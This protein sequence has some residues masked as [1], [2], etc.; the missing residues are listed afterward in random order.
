MDKLVNL[1]ALKWTVIRLYP[2]L[3]EKKMWAGWQS[4]DLYL[5]F[6]QSL[7]TVCT[8]FAFCQKS[9]CQ[10]QP[11]RIVPPHLPCRSCL[12]NSVLTARDS[13]IDPT[14][15]A[16]RSLLVLQHSC[17]SGWLQLYAH[18]HD[19]VPLSNSVLMYTSCILLYTAAHYLLVIAA[20]PYK[21][22]PKGQRI[23]KLAA[24]T[25]GWV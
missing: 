1:K 11:Q 17:P 8:A 25:E 16:C 10:F 23:I 18:H 24:Q 2:Y 14:L 12:C 3:L 20:W 6:T 4:I 19:V 5:S 21:A 9:H 13:T 15:K 7:N 22:W